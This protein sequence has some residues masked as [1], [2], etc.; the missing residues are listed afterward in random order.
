MSGRLGTRSMALLA[1]APVAWS[2]ACKKTS[3]EIAP[4]DQAAPVILASMADVRRDCPGHSSVRVVRDQDTVSYVSLSVSKEITLVPEFHDCQRLLIDQAT[5]YGPL[6][7]VFAS[8]TLGAAQ[9]PAAVRPT[10]GAGSAVS[11][12]VAPPPPAGSFAAGGRLPVAEVVNFDVVDYEPLGIKPLFN[13]LYMFRDASAT[14]GIAA[15]MVS[16][17]PDEAACLK[18]YDPSMGGTKLLVVPQTPASPF[19]WEDIPAVARWDWD[20]RSRRQYI[21]IRCDLQWCEV[22]PENGFGTSQGHYF[23]LD[24]KRERRTWWIKGWHDEQQL[25]VKAGNGLKP[26]PSVGTVVPDSAL[27]DYSDAS[28]P[29]NVWVPAA[30]VTIQP[31]APEYRKKLGLGPVAPNAKPDRMNQLELCKADW[32]ACAAA[33]GGSPSQPTLNCAGTAS[34]W[35]AR[36]IAPDGGIKYFCVIRTAHATPIAGTARWRWLLKDETIWVRCAEGCCQ[37]N[38]EEM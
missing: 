36:M 34:D 32:T 11:Q 15:F 10:G 7:G 23:T 37:V 33:A 14:N 25:A 2:A 19:T 38:S 8:N 20:P 21:G 4:G 18:E 3:Q 24:K 9:A 30:R 12:P 22:G 35:W 31:F 6:V 13:C 27:G 28:F 26:I 1:L 5:T 29:K 17:G 16:V